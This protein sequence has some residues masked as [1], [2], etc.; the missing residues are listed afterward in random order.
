GHT[1]GWSGR[2][3]NGSCVTYAVPLLA[4]GSARDLLAAW[5]CARTRARAWARRTRRRAVSWLRKASAVIYCITMARSNC[6]RL[7]RP[8]MFRARLR[9]PDHR[10]AASRGGLARPPLAHGLLEAH[11]GKAPPCRRALSRNQ[12]GPGTDVTMRYCP[13]V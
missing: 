8:G 6:N 10:V 13:T 5:S 12:K 11:E 7:H 1:E 9:V 2:A 4:D 3:R